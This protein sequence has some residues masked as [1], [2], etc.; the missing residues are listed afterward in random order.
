MFVF[1]L[2]FPVRCR[3]DLSQACA[4]YF[5]LGQVQVY[6]GAKRE[7][8]QDAP[9]HEVGRFAVNLSTTSSTWAA[10]SELARSSSIRS[11]N[12]SA[13]VSGCTA[14]HASLSSL[15]W[16]MRVCTILHGSVI[17]LYFH[18]TFIWNLNSWWERFAWDWTSICNDM[19]GRHSTTK[20]RSFI[21]HQKFHTFMVHDHGTEKPNRMQTFLQASF[22]DWLGSELCT[23]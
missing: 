1:L 5:V 22:D 3:S 10:W 13:R 4:F 18:Q 2:E 17:R 8:V 6:A 11:W 19:N 9:Q 14:P 16:D 21:S 23:L 15:S 7:P 20:P 12:G